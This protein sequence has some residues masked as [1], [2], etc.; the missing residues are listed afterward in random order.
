MSIAGEQ[1]RFILAADIKSE[2][3]LLPSGSLRKRILFGSVGVGDG[4][5]VVRRYGWSL[6]LRYDRKVGGPSGGNS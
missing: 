4:G 1:V 6:A 2:R 5:S 3:M